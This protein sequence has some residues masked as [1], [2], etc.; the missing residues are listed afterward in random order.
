MGKKK[1]KDSIIIIKKYAD[2]PMSGLLLKKG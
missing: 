1:K 2:T